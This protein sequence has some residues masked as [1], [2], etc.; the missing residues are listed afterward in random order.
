MPGGATYYFNSIT[1]YSS[2]FFFESLS[3]CCNLL[4]MYSSELVRA[5]GTDSLRVFF[6]FWRPPATHGYFHPHR[7]CRPCW[8]TDQI[9]VCDIRDARGIIGMSDCLI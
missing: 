2:S 9:Q 7:Y 1:V 8:H 6:F 5:L 4:Y 3:S